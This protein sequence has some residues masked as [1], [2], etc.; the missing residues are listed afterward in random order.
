MSILNNNLNNNDGGDDDIRDKYD[1]WRIRA[2]QLMKSQLYD[3]AI[4]I[5]TK[6]LTVS[7]DHSIFT[8][9]A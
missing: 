1:T 9:R 7:L 3:E 2:I 6:L 4:K 5:F 8:Y